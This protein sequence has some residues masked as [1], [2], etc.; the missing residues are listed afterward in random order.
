MI[1]ILIVIASVVAIIGFITLL[2]N[3]YKKQRK[4]RLKMWQ[5]GDKL[6]P[7]FSFHRDNK[8]ASEAL[9]KSGKEFLTLV[10]FTMKHVFVNIGGIVYKIRLE[11]IDYN[12]SAIWRENYNICK[13]FMGTE[14]GFSSVLGES[15]L[16][17]DTIDGKPIE[18]LTEIE[19]QIYLKQALEEEKFE[20]ADKIRQ[21][22]QKY[23]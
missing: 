8:S 1:T 18:L 6:Y 2:D 12:K 4:E 13:E 5:I 10:G 22:M 7:V 11:Y 16:S 20:L 21:Q 14:P 15:D 3:H 23:R 9:A 19:C 17:K